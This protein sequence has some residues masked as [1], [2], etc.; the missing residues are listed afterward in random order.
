MKASGC[1]IDRL[2]AFRHDIHQNAELAFKEV[3]TSGKVKDLLLLCGLEES[4]IQS[5][6][7][8]GLV[9]DIEGTG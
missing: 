6:A 7:G 5:C 9:V 3:R 2:I 8:T 4:S 1:D